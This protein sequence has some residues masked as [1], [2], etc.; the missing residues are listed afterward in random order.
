MQR[1]SLIA[2][3]YQEHSTFLRNVCRSK[4]NN[5]MEYRDLI[6]DCIQETFVTASESY[7]TLKNHPNIRGWLLQT[8]MN[9][10]M[11]SL[12]TM[13][14]RQHLQAFSLDDAGAPEIA[15]EGGLES[16]VN[17][18]EARLQ[19]TRIQSALSEDEL[20]IFTSY[21]VEHNTMH[22]VAITYAM[23]D[24]QVKNVIKR[25]RRKAV[26]QK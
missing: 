7:D 21:F 16:A 22:D 14:R 19:L 11:A 17:Q 20:K 12:R 25:I 15:D 2:R 8:C 10:L 3:I 4:V 1:Q 9:R 13:R 6:E 26:P 5:Q 23:R 18:N 24:E